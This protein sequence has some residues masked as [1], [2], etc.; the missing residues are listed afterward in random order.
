MA[1]NTD[2]PFLTTDEVAERLRIQKTTLQRWCREGK[3]PYT[4]VGRRYLIAPADLEK[5]L[6]KRTQ[7]ATWRQRGGTHDATEG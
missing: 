5:W 4:R 6:K 7:R 1:A 3:V 2:P